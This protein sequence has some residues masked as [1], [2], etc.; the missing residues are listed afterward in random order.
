L[1]RLTDPSTS[2]RT[3]LRKAGP[4]RFVRHPGYVCCFLFTIAIGLMLG[5]WWDS[6]PPVITALI[7]IWHTAREDKTLQAELPGYVQYA[8]QKRFRLVPDTW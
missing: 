8:T 6:I 1:R 5:S 4:Y 2:L 7:L 3:G